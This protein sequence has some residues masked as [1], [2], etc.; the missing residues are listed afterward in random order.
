[1]HLEKFESLYNDISQILAL[2]LRVVD[3]VS[4]IQVFGLEEVHDG[5]N[6]SVV[7][8]ESFANSVTARN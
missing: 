8:H 6:L 5:Q 4:L 7:G 3:L 1:M 2:A